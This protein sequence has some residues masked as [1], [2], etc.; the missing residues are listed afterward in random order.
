[1][2]NDPLN[3]VRHLE[4]CAARAWPAAEVHDLD[5]WLVRHDGGVTRRANSVLPN[6]AGGRLSLADRLAAVEARYARWGLLPRFQMSAAAEPAELDAVL[7]SRGYVRTAPTVVQTASLAAVLAATVAGASAPVRVADALDEPWL[8]TYCRADGFTGREATGREGIL[9]RI[10]Q[11]TGYA[12]LE[13]DGQLVA[14]GL[15]VL[16]REWVGVFC[17]ATLAE[18]RRRGAAT[19]ILHALARW[20]RATG[21]THAYLQVMDDNPGAIALYARAGFATLYPYHYR[22]GPVMR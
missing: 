7:A 16:D 20:G 12:R 22:Q 14:V 8:A 9:R 18:Y 6:R 10:A 15:G 13:R 2:A 1:M 11:P 3:L 5:G 17:M 21:A 4:D 19:A